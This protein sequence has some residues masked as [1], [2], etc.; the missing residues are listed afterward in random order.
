MIPED[1]FAHQESIISLNLIDLIIFSIS[2]FAVLWP[3]TSF[4]VTGSSMFT[5]SDSNL[6]NS[7]S[8]FL[9]FSEF[10]IL[11]PISVKFKFKS[12]S[13]YLF[14]EYSTKF[15]EEKLKILCL[16]SIPETFAKLFI[17]FCHVEKI[18]SIISLFKKSS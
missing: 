13:T 3:Q 17:N 4:K 7:F 11:F 16:C 6:A 5:L 14:D 1:V 18:E 12:Q 15:L 10:L 9:E 8:S 2:F